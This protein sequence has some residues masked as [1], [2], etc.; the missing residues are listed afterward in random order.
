MFE[1][2]LTE[3]STSNVFQVSRR[4]LPISP[5]ELQILREIKDESGGHIQ[6]SNRPLQELNGRVITAY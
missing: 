5:N 1:S 4:V 2:C 3:S 6:K